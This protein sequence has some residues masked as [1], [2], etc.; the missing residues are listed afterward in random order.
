MSSMNKDLLSICCL[1]FNHS[2]FI[3]DN[4]ES[5]LNINYK[6]IEVI[7]VDDGSSDN[8]IEVLNTI[9]KTYPLSVKIINQKNTGN[10]GL[11]FNN[12]IKEATGELITFISL[13]DVF[14][15]KVMLQQLNELNNQPNLAFIASSKALSINDSGYVDETRPG[16]L[17]LS[18]IKNPQIDD[19]IHLEFEQIGAFYLQGSIFR[20]SIIDSI[21]GFDNDMTGDDIVLRIKLFNYL[22]C[23]PEWSF[24]I[25][26]QNNVFYRL[27]ENNIHKNSARQIKIVTEVWER[28]WPNQEAP[29]LLINW[30]C[31]YIK[32]ASFEQIIRLFTANKKSTELLNNIRIQAAIKK[33]IRNEFISSITKFIYSRKKVNEFKR[34]ITL[35]SFIKF[36]YNKNKEKNT[37]TIHFTKY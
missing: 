35:F 28:Y 12:A 19:L 21:Y 24:Q 26:N 34:V 27:H 13:D 20:R 8:S 17:L 7:V 33:S 32:G 9:K 23:H 31:G 4:L 37:N 6:N 15:S 36:S 14:H 29:E 2:A 1:G 22:K 25:I 5:I 3:K 30:V 16:E 11:N 18:K 10:I